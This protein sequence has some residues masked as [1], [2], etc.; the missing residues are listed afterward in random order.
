[1]PH[2]IILAPAVCQIANYLL[3]VL[4]IAKLV[5]R[6]RWAEYSAGLFTSYV[7]SASIVIMICVLFV[8]LYD[9]NNQRRLNST[10]AAWIAQRY[11]CSRGA[12][13][14]GIDRINSCQLADL[15]VESASAGRRWLPVRIKLQY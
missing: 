11:H 5:H 6:R 8:G 10:A 14:H 2:L 3:L 1:M 13:D 12:L 7:M 9:L 4:C 15:K